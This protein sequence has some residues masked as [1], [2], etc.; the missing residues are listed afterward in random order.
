MDE[1]EVAEDLQ[2]VGE[3]YWGDIPRRDPKGRTLEEISPLSF[4][5]WNEIAV[6]IYKGGVT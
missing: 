1:R 3:S 6:T 2:K 4:P 5:D